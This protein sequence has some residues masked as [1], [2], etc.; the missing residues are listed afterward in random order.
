MTIISNF[1]DTIKLF[2]FPPQTRTVSCHTPGASRRWKINFPSLCF[3]WERQNHLLRLFYPSSHHEGGR[4][5][6][7]PFLFPNINNLGVICMPECIV[8]D[9][10]ELIDRFWNSSFNRNRGPAPESILIGDCTG[11]WTRLPHNL[12]LWSELTSKLSHK[13]VSLKIEGEKLSN[14]YI[15]YYLF[16]PDKSQ[17]G[18]FSRFNMEDAFAYYRDNCVSGVNM[19]PAA[20]NLPG[21]HSFLFG[22]GSF[23]EKTVARIFATY[24]HPEQKSG[25]DELISRM[26]LMGATNVVIEGLL[27]DLFESWFEDGRFGW[28]TYE[29][30]IQLTG[31]TKY[32]KDARLVL[33][34]S[35]DQIK[36]D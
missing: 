24:S 7:V 16:D 35:G 21:W 1:N 9:P 18:C 32:L 22:L 14:K 36:Q 2:I 31:F 19:S 25:I 23:N 8:D 29:S 26:K 33:D 15:N 6:L 28:H 4:I 5:K 13:D 12:D 10:L 27:D 30:N 34:I 11:N 3:V 20:V 17:L